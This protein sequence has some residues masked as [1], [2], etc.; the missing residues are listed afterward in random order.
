MHTPCIRVPTGR[1]SPPPGGGPTPQPLVIKAPRCDANELFHAATIV[2]IVGQKIPPLCLN[3][4]R[5]IG[6]PQ[7][8]LEH[9]DDGLKSCGCIPCTK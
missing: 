2:A 4:W 9:F 3:A 6:V 8:S 5:Q 1:A 7:P